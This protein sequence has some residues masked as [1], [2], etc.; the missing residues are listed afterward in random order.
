MPKYLLNYG[1][2]KNIEGCN[3][4]FNTMENSDYSNFSDSL[5]IQ[6]LI[7]DDSPIDRCMESKEENDMEEEKK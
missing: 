6:P 1:V 3:S 4:D 5:S 2:L 7:S